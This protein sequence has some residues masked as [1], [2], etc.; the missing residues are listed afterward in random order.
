M[1]RRQL[2]QNGTASILI[3]G[4]VPACSSHPSASAAWRYVSSTESDPRLTILAS[5]ILAPSPHNRQPW[6]VALSEDDAS[7]MT[8]YSDLTR[9]LPETDPP[10][11]QVL[12]GLGAFIEAVSLAASDMGRG[13]TVESF[14]EGAPEAKLDQRPIAHITLG[15]IGSSDADP[16]FSALRDRRTSRSKFEDRHVPAATL[17]GIGAAL[18]SGATRWGATRDDAQCA[19]LR[20]LCQ[21]GWRIEIDTPRTHAES[22]ALTRIGRDEISAHP[23]GISLFGPAIG[24]LSGLGILTRNKMR[25]PNSRAFME[26]HDFYSGLIDSTRS[27]G[28][29]MTIDNRR[30]SQL[31]AGRDWLRLHLAATQAGVALQPLSQVLQEFPEMSALY[32]Q[33]HAALSVKPPARIQGLFRL[34]YAKAPKPSP[35]WPLQTRLI[36]VPYE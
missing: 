31:A 8:L 23:D 6:L 9:L 32:T 20:D 27:F 15:P 14:P 22:V 7:R 36:D 12:M 18:V 21:A 25:D 24:L 33:T 3:I 17:A 10:N 16:L 29:L 34:G 5:G 26:T 30:T 35:R 19:A 4:G 11:R 1:N 2:M 28:W 13:V